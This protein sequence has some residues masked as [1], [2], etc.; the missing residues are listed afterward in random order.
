[1]GTILLTGIPRV[2]KSGLADVT[3]KLSEEFYE[4]PVHV[5]SLGG[6]IGEIAY[7][8]WN[9]PP[10][11]LPYLGYELQEALRKAAIPEA[12][13]RL[14]KI[15]T[16]DHVIIDTPLTMFVQERG[17]R[18]PDGIFSQHDIVR[19]HEAR[20][21]DHA[22][23]LIE[24]PHIMAERLADTPYPSTED[25]ILNW[26]SLEAALTQ[27]NSP[28]TNT[29]RTI[30][31]PRAHSDGTLAKLLRDPTSPVCYFAGPITGMGPEAMQAIED[32]KSQMQEYTGVIT[33]L[34]MTDKQ[35]KD[36]HSKAHT[37]HRDIHWFVRYADMI[38]AYYPEDYPEK[39][40]SQG[41]LA[42]MYAT[43]RLG[44]PVILIRPPKKDSVFS[45]SVTL[46]FE[47]KEQFFEAIQKSRDD[48]KYSMLQC[49]LDSNQTVPRYAHLQ[50]FSVAADVWAYAKDLHSLDPKLRDRYSEDTRLHLVGKRAKGRPMGNHWTLITGKRE[51]NNEMG[52]METGREALQSEVW[53]EAGLAHF[54]EELDPAVYRVHR[55]DFGRNP[56]FRVYPVRWVPE[57][58]KPT[59]DNQTNY[60][61]ISKVQWA[62]PKQILSWDNVV[63]GTQRYFQDVA[64]GH[65]HFPIMED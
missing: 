45:P 40:E 25:C 61:E 50:G 41:T 24:A 8:L 30:V 17:G 46:P 18:I 27:R 64:A 39:K 35:V 29:P 14:R 9:T 31:I 65:V 3:Q 32:F 20:T 2:G 57:F 43:A 47:T 49:F 4:T 16:G 37:V 53:Q 59:P 38:V 1:M 7:G 58:G 36:L 34:V 63:A 51:F 48:P 52:R 54:V 6:I 56:Y 26:T 62:T 5:V 10:D 44:K 21:I 19:L 55:T 60:P 42:E 23:S 15:P 11:R 13:D 33:P 12:I 28:Y 22:V